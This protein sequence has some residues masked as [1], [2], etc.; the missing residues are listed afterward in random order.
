MNSGFVLGRRCP[1]NS[2]GMAFAL[3]LICPLVSIAAEPSSGR[4]AAVDESVTYTSGPFVQSTAGEI[5]CQDAGSPCDFFDLEVSLANDFVENNN[6]TFIRVETSWPNLAE[7]FDVSLLEGGRDGGSLGS[8]ATLA[9]PEI[10]MVPVANG[11]NTYAVQ[12]DPFAAAGGT[13]TTTVSLVQGEPVPDQMPATGVAPRFYVFDSPPGIADGAGEPTLGF[14]PNTQRV[15]FVSG[16][17]TDQITF[18]EQSDAV[19]AAGDPLPASCDAQWVPRNYVGNVNTLDPILETNQASGRTFQSQ[20]SG[21]N[22][23]F[24]Y[25]DDDGEDGWTPGQAGP[26]NGGVDHQTVGTG[27]YS[28]SAGAPPNALVDYAVYYCSQSVAAAFCA[29]S[30]DGGVTFGPGVPIFSPTTDCNGDIGGLH[31]HVQ[32]SPSDGTVYVPFGSCGGQQ[33]VSV[34]TDN[35]TTWAVKPIPGST[36]GD[37]PGAAVASDGTLYACYVNDTDGQPRAQVST[38]QGDTWSDPYN[39]GASEDVFSAVFPTAVAGDG[40]RAA[41]AWHATR[42]EGADPT[43]SDSGFEG[44]WYSFVSV[45]YDRGQTWHTIDI[46]P[47]DPIQGAGGICLAGTTCGN[48]RNLLDFFDIQK[49]DEGRVLVAVADG[50]IGPCISDP[51]GSSTFADKGVLFRQSGGRTLFAEFDDSP[52]RFNSAG[53][54]A[55]EAACPSQARSVRTASEATIVWNAPDD[56]GEQVTNY[57]VFR[58]E[59]PTGPFVSVGNAGA[60]EQFVD[61]TGDPGVENYYYRVEATNAVGTS[62]ASNVIELPV[63]VVEQADTCTL[64]GAVIQTSD[65][66]PTQPPQLDIRFV[67]VAEPPEFEGNFAFTMKVEDFPAGQPAAD[68][69]SIEFGDFYIAYDGTPQN[70][71]G[72]P[73]TFGSVSS[74]A[75]GVLTTFTDEGTLDERSFTEADGTIVMVAPK[76]LFENPQPGDALVVT[77]SRTR[78]AT[79]EGNSRDLVDSPGAYNVQGT[80]DCPIP[81]VSLAFLEAD[82]QSGNAP[83]DVTFT[84]SGQPSMDETLQRWSI[85]FGDGESMDGTFDESGTTSVAH[86]YDA[87]GLYQANLVVGDSSGASSAN[88]A[89]RVIE[90]GDVADVQSSASGRSGGALGV[91][92]LGVLLLGGAIRRRRT[93]R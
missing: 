87:D 66:D 16:L 17:E 67:A 65:V 82:R 86:T 64:P 60:K 40:D 4:L 5:S 1:G 19:D 93:M 48:N 69:Y 59:S 75:S 47:D 90:V 41:C 68:F 71:Q 84:I 39:L 15:M 78:S 34:S 26:P 52:T 57:E 31:G 79:R 27:P 33:V 83:L 76:S 92:L 72:S 44:V 89:Q 73:F 21:A 29:R 12:I 13:T 56:G 8:A 45:T 70:T 74:D 46:E 61:T 6:P 2:V 91:A 25:T 49:D 32:V 81:G 3:A 50:C 53:T 36:V 42:D 7:D 54:L 24:S 18:A 77:I 9:N 63:V 30:D 11:L 51:V 55:P 22:S 14:N 23:I 85:D 58:S 10:F 43:G 38:D 20:L 80:A 62:S 88:T 35:G 37:D 28:A